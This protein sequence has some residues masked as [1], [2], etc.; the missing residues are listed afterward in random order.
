MRSDLVDMKVEQRGEVV[1][2]RV[3]GEL[4]LASAPRAGEEIEAA[5]PPSARGLVVD[6]SELDFIDSSGIAMLFTLA[7]RL[8]GRRQELR[9]VTSPG[10]PVSRV[11][12]LVEFGRA[13]PLHADLD[14][15][16][17]EIA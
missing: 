4:D 16:V 15:A 5:V 3:T 1:V 10:E 17:A 9:V 2:A 13:A 8:G 12:D 7:R 11:L 6:F 14:S